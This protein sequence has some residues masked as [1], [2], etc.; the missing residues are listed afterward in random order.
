MKAIKLLSLLL[1]MSMLTS[2]GLIVIHDGKGGVVSDTTS[3]ETYK[4]NDYDTKPIPNYENEAKAYVDALP[5]MDF[6]GHTVAIATDAGTSAIWD[7]V[8]G[9]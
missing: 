7:D 2:C 9:P 3:E 8:E 5:D 4:P 1:V 6:G